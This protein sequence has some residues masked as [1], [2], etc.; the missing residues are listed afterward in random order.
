[1]HEAI[2]K[3]AMQALIDNKIEIKEMV[4]DIDKL[5]KPS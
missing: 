4:L 5:G 3:N 1:M 2:K